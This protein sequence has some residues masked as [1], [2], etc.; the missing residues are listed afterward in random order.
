MRLETGD[1]VLFRTKP[2][3]NPLSWVAAG[4]RFFTR[5][6]YNHV[7]IVVSNWDKLFINEAVE[8][9]VLSI[10]LEGRLDGQEIKIIRGINSIDE[11]VFARKANSFLGKTGYDFSSLL[12]FQLW[13]QLTG[14]WVGK[15]GDRASRRLYCSEYAAYMYELK[16]W[17]TYSPDM[18]GEEKNFMTIFEGEYR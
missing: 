12:L 18:I 10:P 4:I 2:S 13:F 6:R 7:G 5:Y 3:L 1:I 17:W 9:G 14:K 8:K 16:D 11:K 15:K